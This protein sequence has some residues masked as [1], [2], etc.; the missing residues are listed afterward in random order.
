MPHTCHGLVR[1]GRSIVPPNGVHVMRSRATRGL[2]LYGNAFTPCQSAIGVDWAVESRGR[3]HPMQDV[4]GAPFRHACRSRWDP[5]T[6]ER[7]RWAKATCSAPPSRLKAFNSCSGPAARQTSGSL[8]RRVRVSPPPIC[9]PHRSHRC[10]R[11][12][13]VLNIWRRKCPELTTLDPQRQGVDDGMNSGGGL[14]RHGPGRLRASP[15]GA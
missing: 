14:G 5:A 7:T 13:Q 6:A 3:R 12:Q 8:E 10:Q 4:S 9:P 1:R 2:E 11:S 15:S